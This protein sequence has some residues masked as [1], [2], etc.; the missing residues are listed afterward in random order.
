MI[1]EG[2]GL[3]VL[4]EYTAEQNVNNVMFMPFLN[5]KQYVEFLNDIDV[6]FMSQKKTA[7]DVYFPSKLLGLM[8][9]CKTIILSA[10]KESELYKTVKTNEVGLVC[11]YGDTDGLV[12][13]V[14]QVISDKTVISTIN[15][16]AKDYVSQFYRDNVLSKV[17][18]QIN[19]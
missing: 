1:G 11:E 7:F 17:L 10:D 16:K 2:A 13:I 14:N 18:K 3:K 12:N 5:E 8:A 15:E 9:A 6:F 4:K 19:Q